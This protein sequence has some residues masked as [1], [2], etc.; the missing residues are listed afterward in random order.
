MARKRRS[1]TPEFKLEAASLVLHRGYSIPEAC[2]SLDIRESALRRWVS[3]LEAERSVALWPPMALAARPI[4]SA[5][6]CISKS[7]GGVAIRAH[8]SIF[9]NGN[10]D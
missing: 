2:R 3:Q 6:T 10:S 4:P 7:Q 9:D 5:D 1:F 8:T